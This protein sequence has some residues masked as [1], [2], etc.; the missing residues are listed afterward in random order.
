MLHTCCTKRGLEF[1]T[2]SLIKLPKVSCFRAAGR[3]FDR[4][5]LS[6]TTQVYRLRAIRRIVGNAYCRTT[7]PGTCGCESNLKSARAVWV[8]AGTAA[9]CRTGCDRKV[10]RV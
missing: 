10:A 2:S 6:C 8:E 1:L 7:S 4:C 9:A 3:A 5:I